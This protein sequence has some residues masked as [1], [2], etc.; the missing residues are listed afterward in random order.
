[1]TGPTHYTEFLIMIL[2]NQQHRSWDIWGKSI[3]KNIYLKKQGKRN[4]DKID[5]AKAK[6]SVFKKTSFLRERIR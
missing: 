1:M 3:I 6:E 5:N 4:S 2:V